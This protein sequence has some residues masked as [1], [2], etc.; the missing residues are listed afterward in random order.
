MWL[1]MATNILIWSYKN[2]LLST[3]VTINYDRPLNTL[4]DIET[5]GL[6]VCITKNNAPHWLMAT[7]PRA[8]IK[9]IFKKTLE[10]VYRGRPRL[11]PFPG[12]AFPDWVTQG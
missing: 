7:D 3:L 2:T 9:R 6:P 1:F 12:G 10:G 11:Y 8:I 5:S 4:A